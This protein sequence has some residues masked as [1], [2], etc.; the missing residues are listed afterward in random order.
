[1]KR[2]SLVFSPCSSVLLKTRSLFFVV[3]L[4]IAMTLTIH[5][6]SKE[7]FE[8][9]VPKHLPIKVEILYGKRA[10]LLENAEI[11]ITNTGKR[12]ISF[13]K[14][15]VSTADSPELS[16]K[17]RINSLYFGRRELI[18]YGNVANSD[19]P[20]LKPGESLL[21]AVGKRFVDAYRRARRDTHQSIPERYE[22][23]FQA[24]N[25]GDGTGFW[26]TTGAHYPSKKE[27]PFV[28]ATDLRRPFF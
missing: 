12:S 3:G 20:S 14:L 18:T 23:V 7:A 13:L 17:Y 27:P 11:K 5:A 19:D 1:M 4:A 6:Q 28:N 16:I 2:N 21:F 10:E 8:N 25:F 24:L 15:I 9:K 22:L 26:G